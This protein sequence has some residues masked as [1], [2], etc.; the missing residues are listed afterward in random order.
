[1]FIN[2]PSEEQ[3]KIFQRYYTYVKHISGGSNFDSEV[4]EP[5][6][7]HSYA[8]KT[9]FK[10]GFWMFQHEQWPWY[11]E[12]DARRPI[13]NP[14]DRSKP[15]SKL[16]TGTGTLQVGKRYKWYEQD[17][18]IH[19]NWDAKSPFAEYYDG[20]KLYDRIP[21]FEESVRI[22]AMNQEYSTPIELRQGDMEDIDYRN[23]YLELVNEGILTNLI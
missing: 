1:V 13:Q 22:F 14:Y 23:H 8:P 19:T 9:K 10:D 11:Y 15:R 16:L 2:S 5:M 20:M 3:Y 4:H 7:K 21:D 18:M 6:L 17:L 12:K